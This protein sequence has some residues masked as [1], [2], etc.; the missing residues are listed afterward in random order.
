MAASTSDS[1]DCPYCKESINASAVKC[2]HCHSYS[3][4]GAPLGSEV[5]AMIGGGGGGGAGGAIDFE[6]LDQC[7]IKH[8]RDPVEK[9]CECAKSCGFNCGLGGGDNSLGA[10]LLPIVRLARLGAAMRG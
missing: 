2:R 8:L 5:V 7:A 1:R 10:S 4:P 6:C 9:F 3:E